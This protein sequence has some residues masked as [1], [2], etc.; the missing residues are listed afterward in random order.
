MNNQQIIK[1]AKL[2]SILKSV[3]RQGW[4]LKGITNAESVADHVFGVAFLLM[5]LAKHR[6]VNFE[7]AIKMV[8]IH[9]IGESL[10]G[11][12]VYESGN[13]VIASLDKKHADERKAMHTIFKG[14][15]DKEEYLNLWEE[16][17]ERKTPEA[18]LVKL[19]EK[20][21]MAMQALKYENEG[22]EHSLFDE[23]WENTE[24]Y[25]KGSYLEELFEE[26]KRQRKKL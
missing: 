6:K 23:F 21:E 17:R 26:L 16:W 5:L 2:A 4:V 13:K 24:E 9:D 1:I 22:Y 18:Q 11:D 3:K 7:L 15:L 19:V 12:A 25:L 8:L 20:L 14:Y 10:V